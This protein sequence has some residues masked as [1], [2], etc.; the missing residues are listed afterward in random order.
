MMRRAPI[1]HGVCGRAPACSRRDRRA[2]AG[3]RARPARLGGPR[4]DS[5]L[6]PPVRRAGPEPAATRRAP[7]SSFPKS[8]GRH[9]RP[10]ARRSIAPQPLYLQADQLIYDTKNN[11]VIAQGNVEIYYN[12]YILTADQVIYDQ[13][14]NKL[15]GRGQRPAQGSQRQHHAGRPLRGARRFPRRLHPVAERRH[16][17]RHAHRRRA[18]QPARRQHHRVRARQ[19]HALQERSRHAAAVVHQRR[20]HHPR[21]AGRHHHLPGCAV[22]AVRRAGPV[23]ALLPAP[24]P[25]GEAPLAAS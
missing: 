18:R 7:V 15:T 4:P 9:V 11:R 14:V 17:G 2:A 8:Q 12:N 23:P 19:V 16:A 22:R 13:N 5:L 24:R 20:A 3:A 10:D 6:A 21:P 25:V 1:P